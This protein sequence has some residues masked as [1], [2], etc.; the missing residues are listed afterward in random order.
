MLTRKLL[1]RDEVRDLPPEALGRRFKALSTV[2]FGDDVDATRRTRFLQKLLP[3]CD[4]IA[5]D[6]KDIGKIT[7]PKYEYKLVLS[8]YTPIKE[9]AIPYPPAVE[10]WLDG[11]IDAMLQTGRIE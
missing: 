5:V 7:D 6:Q 1:T 11:E 9:Q 4:K 10:K 2:R 8:D 3:I